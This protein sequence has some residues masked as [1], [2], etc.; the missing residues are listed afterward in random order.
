M[1]NRFINDIEKAKKRGTY[2]LWIA[3]GAFLFSIVSLFLQ[4]I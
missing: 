1:N 2:A 3:V 4:I